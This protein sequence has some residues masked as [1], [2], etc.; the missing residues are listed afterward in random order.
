MVEGLRNKDLIKPPLG[1]LGVKNM[2]DYA[3]C[4]H[5]I[6]L[7]VLSHQG[8]FFIDKR[9]EISNLDLIRALD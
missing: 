1:D 9:L 5:V 4:S 2:K 7:A 6:L 3:P 8:F